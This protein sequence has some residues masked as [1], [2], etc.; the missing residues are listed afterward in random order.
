MVL[1]NKIKNRMQDR[2]KVTFLLFQ[3]SF[4]HFRTIDI[5]HNRHT[6]SQFDFEPFWPCRACSVIAALLFFIEL[7]CQQWCYICVSFG[8]RLLVL[9]VQ[10]YFYY[11]SYNRSPT[12]IT[13]V[14]IEALLLL[15]Q[16]PIN[17]RATIRLKVF[18]SSCSILAEF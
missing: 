16:L 11:N 5:Y 4:S 2:F 18:E 1:L 8:Y 15:Q 6:Y 14:T 9:M 17:R 13:I 10:P 12:S 3:N 7:S